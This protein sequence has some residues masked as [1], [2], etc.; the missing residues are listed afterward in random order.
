MANQVSLLDYLQNALPAIPVNP[1][2]NPGRN[3]TNTAYEANDIHDVRVWHGFSLDVLRQRY[4]HVL[5]QTHLSPDPM[6]TSPLRPV[7]AE[8]ALRSKISEYVFLRVRRALRAEFDRLA[9]INQMNGI[10]PVSFDVGEC[11]E[12]IDSFKSDTAYFAVALPASSGPN[13]AP[14]DV[15]PSWK[16]STTL[17]TNPIL[18]IRNEYRQALSQVNW[19][20]KQHDSRY[21]FILTDRELIVFR[22]VDNNGNLELAPPIPFTIGGTA[23]QPRL[24]VLLALWYLGMLA[25]QDG[26]E[27][28]RM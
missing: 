7:T 11:A 21:G 2:P 26:P 6:P 17:A 13:R 23:E 27:G 18:G 4:Q 19:Y 24:T 22:R 5:V 25:A 1:P 16:W 3:T 12:V 14:G 8:N 20:M 28:W 10:S 9:A 15:K